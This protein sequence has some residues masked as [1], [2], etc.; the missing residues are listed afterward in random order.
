MYV[1]YERKKSKNGTSLISFFF[2]QAEDGIRDIGV[3][4]V[5]TC[6]LPISRRTCSRRCAAYSGRGRR[7]AAPR[8]RVHTVA[9]P[10]HSRCPSGSSVFVGC[11]SGLCVRDLR[12]PDVE[13]LCRSCSESSVSIHGRCPRALGSSSSEISSP[14]VVLR[15]TKECERCRLPWIQSGGRSVL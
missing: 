7:L 2:F 12:S 11:R 6:A 14:D 4:G 15:V 3:T 10:V 9:L 1:I 13:P 5:Q 8:G